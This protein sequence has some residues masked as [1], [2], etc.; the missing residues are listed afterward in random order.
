MARLLVRG[1]Q[2]GVKEFPLRP[3]INRVGRG[4]HNDLQIRDNT[5]SGSHCEIE[6][7]ADAVIVRDLGSTNGTF[8]DAVP[9]REAVLRPGQVLRVGA[10]EM[11]YDDERAATE[12]PAV[13]AAIPTG[14]PAVA[15]PAS[16]AKAAGTST[17]VTSPR[18]A[19]APRVTGAAAPAPAQVTDFC[20][21]HPGT[22]ARL[23]C[24]KCGALWCKGCVRTVRTG[25]KEFHSCP[26]C[27]V[28]CVPPEQYRRATTH[29]HASFFSLLPGAFSYPLKKDGLFLLACGTVFFGFLDLARALLERFQFGIFILAYWLAVIIGLGYIFV[30]MQNIIVSTTHGDQNMPDWP[31]V[32]NVVEGFLFP[33]LQLGLIWLLCLLPGI[34]ALMYVWPVLGVA[35]MGLG[36]FCLPM[37]L[38]T[39][40]LADSLTGMNPLIILSGIAKV[41]LEYLATCGVFLFALAVRG[42]SQW[43]LDYSP[44]PI[45]PL[46]IGDLLGLY[47][48]T[49]VMRLLGLLY[50]A[51]KEKLAWFR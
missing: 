43:L 12:L 6:W 8:I 33:F 44:I 34:L 22:P 27:G 46:V 3:G 42:G 4:A 41:P 30:F 19:L 26:E 29:V 45:L 18:A 50:C 7:R 1:E 13:P 2:A 24:V 51:N 20:V 37:A 14:G 47:V 17:P 40:S 10:V 5:I 32:S 49:V 9:V 23:I 16:A 36:L 25:V 39:V 11:V 15:R 28:A 48:L 38:L 31:E 21:R 35:L